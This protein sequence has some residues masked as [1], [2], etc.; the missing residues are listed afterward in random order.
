MRYAALAVFLDLLTAFFA[1]LFFANGEATLPARINAHLFLTASR[2][3]LRPAA[4]IVRFLVV[5]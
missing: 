1:A 2:I 3:A 5:G 4:L